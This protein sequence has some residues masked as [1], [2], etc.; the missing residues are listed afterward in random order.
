MRRLLPTG[1]HD[2]SVDRPVDE[3]LDQVYADVPPP[4]T[5]PWTAV[6][7]VSSVD[8]AVS[9]D[10]TSGAL[11]GAGDLA[12]F[13]ALRAAADVVLVG[14][15]TVRAEDYGPVRIRP[16]LAAGRRSRGQ[17][18]RPPIAV[19]T[20]SL[21]LGPSRRLFEGD[22]PPPIMVTT[23]DAPADARTRLED[24]GAEVIVAGAGSV[25]LRAALNALRA[26]CG[27]RVLVEGGPRLNAELLGAGLVDELF[28]TLAPTVA[29]GAAGRIVAATSASGFPVALDLVAVRHHEGDLLLRYRVRGG[30]ADSMRED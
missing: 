16:A 4:G 15:G 17:A 14:I 1:G 29:G 22:G 8:G 7:M 25:D 6:S 3:E 30:G 12:A 20:R 26:R 2:G 13:R 5:A 21:D 9:V 24:L 28:L 23:A 11:G 10:G 18:E 27:P 19:V